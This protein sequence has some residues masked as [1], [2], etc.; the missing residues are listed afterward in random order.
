MI[1]KVCEEHRDNIDGMVAKKVQDINIKRNAKD[2]LRRMK[3]IA[4]ALDKVQ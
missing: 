4:V 2:Y 3:P 1:Q